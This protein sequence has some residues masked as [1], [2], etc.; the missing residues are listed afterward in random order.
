M[1][2]EIYLRIWVSLKIDVL[3]RNFFFFSLFEFSRKIIKKKIFAIQIH[4]QYFL[5]SLITCTLICFHLINL[6]YII[7]FFYIFFFIFQADT[8]STCTSNN[9]F[10]NFI[11]KEFILLIKFHLKNFIF[12]VTFCI[13]SYMTIF[14]FINCCLCDKRFSVLRVKCTCTKGKFRKFLSSLPNFL[15][16]RKQFYIR[17]ERKKIKII[18]EA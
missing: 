9:C 8:T 12:T 1:R 17:K 14:N 7:F 15:F 5:I 3:D 4:T 16:C 2:N 13:S 11:N 6:F 10:L 18:R